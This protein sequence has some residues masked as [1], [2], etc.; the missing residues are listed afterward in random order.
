MQAPMSRA[1]TLAVRPCDASVV[2]PTPSRMPT[3]IEALR[4]GA[5]LAAKAAH[6]R[7]ASAPPISLACR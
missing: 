6:I 3:L 7:R 5:F 2:I 4:D 1:A